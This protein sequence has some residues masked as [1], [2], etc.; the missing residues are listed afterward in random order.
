MA[1][2]SLCVVIVRYWVG[3]LGQ[4][5]SS[6]LQNWIRVIK[7]IYVNPLFATENGN[8]LGVRLQSLEVVF[9]VNLGAVRVQVDSRHPRLAELLHR[10]LLQLSKAPGYDRLLDLPG[11]VFDLD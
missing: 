3:C 8:Q 2:S 9:V 5:Q 4:N 10:L 7:D 1:S 11:Y 6:G